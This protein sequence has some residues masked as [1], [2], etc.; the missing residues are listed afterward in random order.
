MIYCDLRKRCSISRQAALYKLLS[1]AY[2]HTTSLIYCSFWSCLLSLS[3]LVA[4]VHFRWPAI[5]E[6]ALEVAA[7][8]SPIDLHFAHEAL[9]ITSTHH[10]VFLLT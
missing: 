8:L 7:A 9:D 10:L 6:A 1:D 2:S 4:K 3:L 5:V